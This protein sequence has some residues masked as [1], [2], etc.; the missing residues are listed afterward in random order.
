LNVGFW[1]SQSGRTVSQ[2]AWKREGRTPIR[3]PAPFLRPHVQKSWMT[4]SMS[5][6]QSVMMFW[7][8]PRSLEHMISAG[9]R[10]GL[11]ESPRLDAMLKQLPNPAFLRAALRAAAGPIPYPPG[12]SP[13]KAAAPD[14]RRRRGI[15]AGASGVKDSGKWHVASGT[16]NSGKWLVASIRNQKEDRGPQNGGPRYAGFTKSERRGSGR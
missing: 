9:L 5:L 8:R 16:E 3:R 4:F 10:S 1:C 11:L 14:D 7:G 2:Q 12:G 15:R 13:P 6:S